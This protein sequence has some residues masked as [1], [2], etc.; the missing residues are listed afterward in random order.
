MSLIF[1]F[2]VHLKFECIYAIDYT[3]TVPFIA[4]PGILIGGILSEVDCMMH[5]L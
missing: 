1:Y 2:D 5:E 4:S 3:V